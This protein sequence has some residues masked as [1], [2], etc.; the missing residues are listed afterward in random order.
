VAQRGSEDRVASPLDMGLHRRASA[1]RTLGVAFGAWTIVGA[2]AVVQLWAQASGNGSALPDGRRVVRVFADV[3]AWAA[4]TPGILWLAGRLPIEAATWRRRVPAH[5]AIALAVAAADACFSVAVARVV[6]VSP[7]PGVAVTL[8]RMATI[9]VLS[10]AAVVALGHAIRY[11]RLY[12]ERR[13]RASELE[14]QLS[15]ARL[16]ALEA[17]LRPHFL[18]N[19]LHTVASLVRSGEPDLAV[20]TIARLGEL[21]RSLL[22][23]GGG[24][25][26]PLRD[27]L[28]FVGRYLEVERARFG[29]RLATRVD[30]DAAVLDALVPRFVLQPLVENAVRHGVEPYDAAGRVEVRAARAGGVLRLEVL[31]SGPG[32]A[33]AQDRARPGVGLA[34]TR[35]R[36]RQLYG[37]AARLDLAPAP[38]GGTVAV[39]ELPWRTGAGAERA[40]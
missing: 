16:H 23:D 39:L 31:D 19:A 27:E 33:P 25:E 3:W 2:V 13:L 8:A 38:G 5:A 29:D 22:S 30:A 35:A 32:P 40:A 26:I 6:G 28:A 9:D 20:R 14:R 4:A 17:Q 24:Q 10:Y 7:L 36:L 37:D 15:E 21:L 12:V 11:H 1:R 18:F 34:N